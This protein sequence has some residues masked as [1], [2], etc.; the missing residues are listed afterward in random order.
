MPCSLPRPIATWRCRTISRIVN[1]GIQQG[2]V[3]NAVPQAIRRRQMDRL[4]I[5]L[6][7]ENRDLV[8]GDHIL[9]DKNSLDYAEYVEKYSILE[10]EPIYVLNAVDAAEMVRLNPV[11]AR[12]LLVVSTLEQAV[13]NP[14]K[15]VEMG[16]GLGFDV[17]KIP[18][19]T[20]LFGMR[21][22]SGRSLF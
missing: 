2:G 20:D 15:A 9:V 13:A 19:G 5:F 18:A 17:S 1:T 4:I 16:S 12:A 3:E 14:A 10:S 7:P 21:N 8:L 6:S 11:I 22:Y